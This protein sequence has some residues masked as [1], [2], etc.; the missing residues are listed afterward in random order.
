MVVLLTVEQPTGRELVQTL[1]MLSPEPDIGMIR[2]ASAM[3]A[4]M[5]FRWDGEVLYSD[6]IF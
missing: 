4:P 5:A 2:V 3:P 1:L 6:D